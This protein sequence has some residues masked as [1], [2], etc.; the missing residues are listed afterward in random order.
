MLYEDESMSL[1]CSMKFW[2]SALPEVRWIAGTENA[3]NVEDRTQI[4][5]AVFNVGGKASW[6]DN[7]LPYQCQ[8][9]YLD[10]VEQCE[11]TMNVMCKYTY[12]KRL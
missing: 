8:M 2:G 6:E 9:T 3:K 12:S 4:G 5:N 10:I 7:K 1:V 11:L